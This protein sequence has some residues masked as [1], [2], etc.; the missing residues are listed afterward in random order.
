ML[1]FRHFRRG[2]LT[3]GR[4][5]GTN[6]YSVPYLGGLAPTEKFVVAFKNSVSSLRL[7]SGNTSVA[8]AQK[9]HAV[10]PVPTTNNRPQDQHRMPPPPRPHG[11]PVPEDP[12]V[13]ENAQKTMQIIQKELLWSFMGGM[14][15]DREEM[16]RLFRDL[17]SS[18]NTRHECCSGDA[19]EPLYK[20][21]MF[22]PIGRGYVTLD[23]FRIYETAAAG[24]L[25]IIVGGKK[26]L[27]ETFRG[28]ASGGEYGE[29]SLD[30]D[31]GG[32]GGGSGEDTTFVKELPPFVY[33]TNWETAAQMAKEL[34]LKPHLYRERQIKLTQWFMNMYWFM[35]ERMV[36]G[37]EGG[38]RRRYLANIRN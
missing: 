1:G 37:R 26:E 30:L 31:G 22:V 17:S 5:V 12:I 33:A 21:S 35:Q 10:A 8:S 29:E 16:I 13:I 2:I 20:R 27:Y 24:A 36:Y 23:C 4:V 3:E 7:L 19:I 28:F 11:E 18:T 38:M 6:S 9:Q 15:S 34:L 25:P 32:F 14:K